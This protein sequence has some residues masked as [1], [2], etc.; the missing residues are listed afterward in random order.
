MHTKADFVMR[1]PMQAFSGMRSETEKAGREKFFKEPDGKMK[2]YLLI[3]QGGY[4][5]EEMRGGRK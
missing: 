1:R 5:L 4:I 2:K 3:V